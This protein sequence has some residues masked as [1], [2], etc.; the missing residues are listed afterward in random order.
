VGVFQRH[1]VTTCREQVQPRSGIFLTRGPHADRRAFNHVAF[2]DFLT[3]WK[4][5]DPEIPI[6]IEANAKCAKL[7]QFFPNLSYE[8]QLVDD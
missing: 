5:G 1:I 3:L 2:Q 4:D 8:K 7:Q 6:P